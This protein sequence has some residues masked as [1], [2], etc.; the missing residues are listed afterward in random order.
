M[1]LAPR[2]TNQ[3]TL[4]NGAIFM[5][6]PSTNQSTLLNGAIFMSHSLFTSWAS[7]SILSFPRIHMTIQT[8]RRPHR[9]PT[10]NQRTPQTALF[11]MQLAPRST[12]HKYSLNGTIFMLHSLFTSW[13]LFLSSHAYDK[14]LTPPARST[15]HQ[16]STTSTV[17][18]M[19]RAK[20]G[21]DGHLQRPYS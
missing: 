19:M 18:F 10:D 11:F 14:Q 6:P 4:L 17:L 5:A 8:S 21:K 2:P 13:A 1:Q 9:V 15:G 12:N 3:S 20:E 7:M 16:R